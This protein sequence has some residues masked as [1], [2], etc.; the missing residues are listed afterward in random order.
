MKVLFRVDASAV[1]GIGHVMRCLTL[2]RS[3]RARGAQVT[4]ACRALD[5]NQIERIQRDFCVLSLPATY[6]GELHGLTP[7]AR[8]CAVADCAAVRAAVGECHFDWCVLDH[9]GLGLEWQHRVM[10]FCRRLLVIDDLPQRQHDCDLLLDQNL[11]DEPPG[12]YPGCSAL[13][14]FGPRYSL[15]REE[16]AY[17]RDLP[18]PQQHEQRPR[19]LLFFGGGASAQEL[20]RVLPALL[21]LPVLL[22]IVIGSARPERAALE[23]LLQGQPQACLH[24]NTEHMAKLLHATDLYV[25]SGGT[26]TWE[27]ACL[28]VPGVVAALSLNQQAMSGACAEAGLQVYLGESHKLQPEDWQNA[29]SQLLAQP[30]RLAL[31]RQRATE[32]VDGLG[33]VRV[34]EA[35][36]GLL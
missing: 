25:G 4:F 3:L 17:Y 32:L 35:M 31:M 10:S 21:P 9:Y 2:A 22:D 27:R 5:G 11:L 16:F 13:R 8:V 12:I 26:V 24:V 20:L 33:V 29:V 7:E 19:V 6:A 36:E 1:M 15:L 23:Q 34:V 28:G 14:L 30:E 18:R